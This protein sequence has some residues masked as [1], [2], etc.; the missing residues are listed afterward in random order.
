MAPNKHKKTSRDSLRTLA[1]LSPIPKTISPMLA[2]LVDAPFNRK[3]WLF[4][5]KWDGIRIIAFVNKN[6][7]RLITRNKKNYSSI[8]SPI[9]EDLKSLQLKA[10]LDGEMVV[11]DKN[12]V[13][14]FQLLQQYQKNFL[15]RKK[16]EKLIYYVFDL[17]WLDGRDLRNLPL[18]QRKQLL[19]S[20]LPKKGNQIQIS[21]HINTKGKEFFK[22]ASAHHIEGIMGK[23]GESLY[24][25]GKRLGSWVKIKTH[26]QQEAIICGYTAP[27]G[28]RKFIG[29]LI[30]GAYENGKLQY[31]GHTGGKLSEDARSKLKTRLDRIAKTHSPFTQ[32]I[33]TN[34]PATWVKP[35]IVCE[36]AF[37]EWTADHH[38]RQ[39]IFL[40]LRS[41]KSFTSVKREYPLKANTIAKRA[42]PKRSSTKPSTPMVISKRPVDTNLE[43]KT[44]ENKTPETKTIVINKHT[45]PLTHLTKIYWPKEKYTKNDL[46]EYYQSVAKFILP[47]L[48][49]RPQVLHRHPNGIA[50]DSFYQKNFEAKIPWLKT[51]KI[52]SENESINY[53]I[54]ADAATLIYMVNL[55][56][57]EINPWISQ[58]Q[59]LDKPDYCVLD[60]DPVGIDFT[61][62]I[63]V[64][65]TIHQLLNKIGAENYC[66]TSGATGLHVYIPLGAKYTY[67]QSRNFAYL[68]ATMINHQLPDITSIKRPPSQRQGKVYLDYLQNR[69]GQTLVAPYSV[70]P[71]PQA[72]VSTPLLWKEVTK[73]LRPEQFTIKNI[74]ARLKNAGDPWKLMQEK[75]MRGKGID[76][77]PCLK[78]IEKLTLK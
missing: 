44:L 76:L 63:Q 59:H 26:M 9:V 21:E 11:V 62:V 56:C 38:M 53:L 19:A 77:L 69:H 28:S 33:K 37:M 13:S 36:V 45:L 34:A 67:E 7:V 18:S 42:L 8:F 48:K 65:Q 58:I 25:E 6:N 27:R 41:D 71:L 1:P 12:G 55:G 5:I 46:I 35:Q 40:G 75:T 30:L 29:A 74:P 16:N 43:I 61:A 3:N 50:S 49:D 23:D 70:R 15:L 66:K 54:G 57:I 10:I 78:H 39:P 14:H 47:Y 22:A 68:I 64:A 17:L 73:K 72:P 4:E 51:K 60:L 20:I 2:T 52:S 32:P 24:Q 31:I